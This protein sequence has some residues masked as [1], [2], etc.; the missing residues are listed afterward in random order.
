[1]EKLISEPVLIVSIVVWNREKILLIKRATEPFRGTWCFIAGHAEKNESLLAAAQ[2][3]TE[4]EAGLQINI[5]NIIDDYPL[6]LEGI[7][8]TIVV[9]KAEAITTELKLKRD[10]VMEAKWIE[11]KEALQLSD[12]GP[13]TKKILQKII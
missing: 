11:P 12:L 8:H 7:Q 9:F 13:L 6:S 1:M 4:E 10:E 5:L 2:R 3:E